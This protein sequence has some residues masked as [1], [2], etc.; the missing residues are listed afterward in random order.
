MSTTEVFNPGQVKSV[1]SEI[2]S[3]FTELSSLIEET[4][5]LITEAL[6]SPD[7]AVYGDAG[8]KILATWDENCST[9]N[10]FIKIYDNW[11]LMAVSIANEYGEL[12]TGTAKVDGTDV[13]AFKTI[14]GANK[15]T[16]LKT[17]EG[18]KG[19]T[20]STSKYR[21]A[22]T[23]NDMEETN[24]LSGRRQVTYTDENGHKVTEYYDLS[25]VLIGKEINGIK[26]DV[27]GNKVSNIGTKEELEREEK[28][29]KAQEALKPVIKTK[30]EE[31]AKRD[32]ERAES[33]KY[34]NPAHLSGNQLS[35]IEKIAPGAIKAY[36]EYGVLPSL[37]LAQAILESGWGKYSIGNNIFGIKAGSSWTGKTRRVKT[38]EQNANGSYYSIYADF[39]DYDSI[40]ES[41]EDHAKLLSNSHY[42]QYGVNTSNNYTE[43]CTRVKQAGY[44]TSLEYTHNLIKLIEQYGLD[45]W[46]KGARAVSSPS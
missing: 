7:R 46:D 29:K 19:Y 2:S 16:W 40:A 44:A 10:S 38:S 6:G 36:K 43:A 14:S 12:D 24:S 11:S 33:A 13:E 21:D 20:G 26:Y 45:Q 9:L 39:R 41:I 17:P 35:F 25:G 23:N 5:T 18:A 30:H 22:E 3:D 8:N 31:R 37:T 15:T 42:S 28:V 32:K 4:N 1:M 34:K 27:E